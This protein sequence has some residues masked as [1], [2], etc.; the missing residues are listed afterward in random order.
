MVL[1]VVRPENPRTQG[2]LTQAHFQQLTAGT[3]APMPRRVNL[4]EHWVFSGHLGGNFGKLHAKSL[5]VCGTDCKKA[6][7]TSAHQ[8]RQT[9][10]TAKVTRKFFTKARSH[11]RGGGGATSEGVGRNTSL[12]LA[13]S[14]PS[15]V[16]ST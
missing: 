9:S 12:A 10:E 6:V 16:S 15:L 1:T 7:L 14:D 8:S 4:T 2:V 5:G 11:G 13:R 3:T